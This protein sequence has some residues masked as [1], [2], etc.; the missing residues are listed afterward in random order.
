MA[1]NDL[2]DFSALAVRR[3][4]PGPKV[5]TRHFDRAAHYNTFHAQEGTPSRAPSHPFLRTYKAAMISTYLYCVN[6]MLV[7]VALAV[8]VLGIQL[9]QHHT[10]RLVGAV[11]DRFAMGI[12]VFGLATFGFALFGCL[13]ARLAHRWLLAVHLLLL[14]V[15]VLAVTTV[16]ITDALAMESDLVKGW[17]KRL[18]TTMVV[19]HPTELCDLQHDLHCSGFESNC[20]NPWTGANTTGRPEDCPACPDPLDAHH[21]Q[22]CWLQLQSEIAH[23]LRPLLYAALGT[24]AALAFALAATCVLFK[25]L[26]IPDSEQQLYQTV[27]G[28]A[29]P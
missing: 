12:I 17:V 9:G 10:Q 14:V 21:S 25:R 23:N 7:V 19:Q 27:L 28:Q 5:H 3:E 2:T 18:W 20:T 16:M 11:S 6:F 13:A 15:L 24:W 26:R 4:S 8:I 22:A 1:E 29:Q